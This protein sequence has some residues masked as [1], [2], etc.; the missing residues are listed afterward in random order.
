MSLKN[1]YFKM[2]KK[3]F[4][5]YLKNLKESNNTIHLLN[6]KYF[7]VQSIDVLNMALELN[8]KMTK[9]D[10]ILNS[11]SEFAKRQIIQSFLIDE[12]ESTNEIENI[13][14][15]RH[16]ILSVINNASQSRNKKII[17][18]SNAYKQ[19]LETKGVRINTLKDIRSMYDTILC[20]AIEKNDL[21]D[22]LYF[23]T[24]DV[25]ISDGFK[26]IHLGA[27]GEKNV[28]EL[29][30]EFL[31]LYNSNNETFIKMIL[32]HFIFENIHPFYDG[33]GRLGR[34]LFSNGLY[35]ETNSYFS[36]AISSS[37]EHEK[38]KYYKAFEKA[39]DKYEFCCL[40]EFVNII[41]S[42]LINQIDLLIKKLEDDKKNMNKTNIT[43]GLTKSEL[44]IYNLISEASILSFFGL[45]NEEIMKEA[46]VSKRTLIYTLN[47]FKEKG[48]LLDTKIGKITYHK[49][50]KV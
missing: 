17:S 23:R 30:K 42:I 6:N 40:N 14:S 12:I 15:T 27:V 29:M 3:E 24:K 44:R 34:F 7:F 39:D 10:M 26:P 38:D 33:N 36:F 21:P 5:I 45:S 11:Y 37:I 8:K 13:H 50:K 47:K 28:N 49:I 32:C 25:Y 18:I 22:G 4:D 16:D 31:S 9:L 41:L 2:G 19:L 46:N 20:D 1:T 35:L 48:I 43:M